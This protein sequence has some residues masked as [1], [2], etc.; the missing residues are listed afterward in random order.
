MRGCDDKTFLDADTWYIQ[1]PLDEYCVPEPMQ[2]NLYV[3]IISARVHFFYVAIVFFPGC[4]D[5]FFRFSV[6]ILDLF[7]DL[8]CDELCACLSPYTLLAVCAFVLFLFCIAGVIVPGLQSLLGVFIS[9]L[10][11]FLSFFMD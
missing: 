6:L 10:C 1:A 4:D 2:P 8:E 5:N 9:A 7:K 3:F 11:S